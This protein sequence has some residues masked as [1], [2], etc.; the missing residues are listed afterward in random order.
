MLSYHFAISY[1]LYWLLLTTFFSQK[2]LETDFSFRFKLKKNVEKFLQKHFNSLWTWK[3]I[4][5]VFAAFLR[6]TCDD[7]HDNMSQGHGEHWS[8]KYV[9]EFKSELNCSMWASTG[10]FVLFE[11]FI[12]SLQ[13]DIS[14]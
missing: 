6:V 11:F 9:F 1:P 4:R 13:N 8:W 10:Y 2:A 5:N 14:A 12:H 7:S 3:R